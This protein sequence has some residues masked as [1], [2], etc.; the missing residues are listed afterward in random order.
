MPSGRTSTYTKKTHK[1]ICNDITNG[2]NF[3]ASM[4]KNGYSQSTGYK[5]MDKYPDFAED[6]TK[7]FTYY[8]MTK[9]SELDEWRQKKSESFPQMDWREAEAFI[10]RNIQALQF[11]LA[12]LAP[13]LTEKYKSSQKVN[14]EHSGQVE[15]I[16]IVS[17]AMPDTV[18]KIVN[19]LEHEDKDV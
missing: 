12:K 6:V 19:S 1:A 16:E 17:Y 11:E 15:K 10:K 2:V 14:M 7:A 3:K 8:F 9:H 4:E 5:W 13:V 18:E